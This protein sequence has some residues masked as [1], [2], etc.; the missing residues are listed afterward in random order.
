MKLMSQINLINMVNRS[1][2]MM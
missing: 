1:I 2:I